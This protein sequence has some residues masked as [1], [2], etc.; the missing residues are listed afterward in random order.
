VITER[1]LQFIWQFQYYNKD[2]LTTVSGEGLTVLKAGMVNSD[3]G[4]DFL[5]ARIRIGTQL[6]VGNIELHV[7]SDDWFR[8]MHDSDPNYGNVVLHVVWRDQGRH[9]P[10]V[11]V[12]EIENRV[13]V[14]LLDRYRQWMSAA[15]FIPCGSSVG[16]V[17]G[18][19]LLGWKERLIAERLEKKAAKI[20]EL[21]RANRFYWEEALWWLVARNFG[22]QV[23]ADAFEAIAKSVS[24]RT[25]LRHRQSLLQLEALFLGQA[26]LLERRPGDDYMR[27]LRREYIFLARKYGL[28]RIMIPVHFLRM[29]PSSFP[30]LRLAQLALLIHQQEHLLNTVLES[31]LT[32]LKG[33]F[34]LQLSGYWDKHYIPGK[35]SV[36][37]KKRTGDQLVQHLLINVVVPFLY[38]YGK[39]FDDSRY[40]ERAEELLY[41][42]PSEKN[43]I[44][45]GFDKLGLKAHLAAD[46]QFLL[47]LRS[48]YCAQWRCLDC[49]IGNYILGH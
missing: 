36:A 48:C 24:Y 32:S 38:A 46:S 5:G 40:C 12:L 44:I 18:L 27:G 49:A 43:R 20:T 39:H 37:G 34:S 9:P 33:L 15:S 16:L 2:N 21:L 14:M 26:G 30:V 1:L 47:E 45:T 8:H 4:P 17:D 29:R 23:N 28:K 41:G 31:S 22:Q 11:A 7:D 3:Q 19:V 25:I 13:P 10:G 35:E 42:L 6:W